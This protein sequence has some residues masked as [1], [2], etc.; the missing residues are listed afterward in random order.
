MGEGSNAITGQDILGRTYQVQFVTDLQATN[1]QTL[2]TATANSSGTFQ[3]IDANAA[4]AAILSDL[5]PLTCFSL[6]SS[7]AASPACAG[8]PSRALLLCMPDITQGL[9]GE[10]PCF[11]NLFTGRDRTFAGIH[12]DFS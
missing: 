4:P 10:S 7:P 1:W 9:W 3:F 6:R 8:I 12:G 2:G 5:V 11:G